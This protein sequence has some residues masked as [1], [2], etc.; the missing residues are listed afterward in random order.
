[1]EITFAIRGLDGQMLEETE[2]RASLDAGAMPSDEPY[3]FGCLR[4]RHAE[5]PDL[6]M[7][8]D[9]NM[10]FPDC[11]SALDALR[12][13]KQAQLNMASYYCHFTLIAEGDSVFVLQDDGDVHGE[14]V[15]H[16][17]KGDLIEALAACCRRFAAYAEMLAARDPKWTGLRDDM[18][19]P[20]G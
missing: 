16:Y 19:I 5:Q 17:P 14:E 1:M 10:L 7:H 13:N 6:E 18:V 4:W 20:S 12:R 15:A 9:L 3:L 8:D 2:A 11:L